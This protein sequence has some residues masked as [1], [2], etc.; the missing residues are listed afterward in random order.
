[1]KAIKIGFFKILIV[2]QKF[3]KFHIVQDL[4]GQIF[5][6]NSYSCTKNFIKTGIF[7][8]SQVAQKFILGRQ[9]F[10]N[11]HS[12][13]KDYIIKILKNIIKKKAAYYN[14]FATYSMLS[15]IFL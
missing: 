11:S 2:A 5:F 14:Y 9:L 3:S 13:A 10:Q 1:M 8:N 4:M 7:R 15:P 12:Y 6:K